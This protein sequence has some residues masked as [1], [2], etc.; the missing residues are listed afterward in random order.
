MHHKNGVVFL[1][2]LLLFVPTIRLLSCVW[3]LHFQLDVSSSFKFLP[4]SLVIKPHVRLIHCIFIEA[5]SNH[6]VLDMVFL[7]F[8]L[9]PNKKIQ[10]HREKNTNTWSGFSYLPSF[11]HPS[12]FLCLQVRTARCLFRAPKVFYFI[13][14]VGMKNATN[15]KC[16]I[17][18][19]ANGEIRS[20]WWR[21]RERE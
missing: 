1:L 12:I 14:S 4:F 13:K 7:G 21:D 10:T 5:G 3:F 15:E 19:R 9:Q 8:L 11:F 2:L 17:I 18:W 6:L 16:I 20:T